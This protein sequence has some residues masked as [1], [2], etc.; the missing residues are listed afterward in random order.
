MQKLLLMF[1]PGPLEGCGRWECPGLVSGADSESAGSEIE[2]MQGVSSENKKGLHVQNINCV[3]FILLNQIIS[4]FSGINYCKSWE[5]EDNLAALLDLRK[6]WGI[7][8]SQIWQVTIRKKKEIR[9]C[10]HIPTWQLIFRNG[11][12]LLLYLVLERL[13]LWAVV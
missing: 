6:S 12:V 1:S 13:L 4:S 8:S 9:V 7:C 10:L 3:V 2:T 11:E 5:Q